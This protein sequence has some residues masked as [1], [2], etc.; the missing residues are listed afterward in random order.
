[1]K[2]SESGALTG[3]QLLDML[4]DMSEEDL[5]LPV[6]F[7]YPAGDYWKTEIAAEV[8]KVEPGSISY[9]GYHQKF[10]TLDA[11]KVHEAERVLE[12]AL[13]DPDQ[14]VEDD[15]TPEHDG[16]PILQVLLIG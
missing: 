11:D 12:R 14:E 3:Q 10:Q 8:C 4:L 7:T 13:A 9:S 5:A 2:H 16:Q 1:M 15:P 6:H